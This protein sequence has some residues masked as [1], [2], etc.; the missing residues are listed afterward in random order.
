[1][2]KT[3]KAGESPLQKA[4][5]A[6]DEELTNF[7]ALAQ[8]AQRTPLTSERNL[9]KA[10]QA[11][12]QAAESQQRVHGHIQAL[13]DAISA[14]RQQHDITAETLVKTRDEVQARGERFQEQLGKFAA[15]GKE[16]AEISS[17]VR[18][19]GELKGKPNGEVVAQLAD[20][21][22]RMAQVVDGATALEKEADAEA[23]E[24]L[25]RNC[26]SLR[27]QVQSA[28]N[29]VSLLREKLSSTMS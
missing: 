19:L 6:L 13:I 23:M 18:Q 11:I 15:L 5:Q 28:L 8:S 16:A 10:A 24:D 7:D 27:Q 4:V 20:V 25:A 17:H 21:Q 29:K 3:H 9:E 12:N 26:D 14:A 22:A 2:N 1:M